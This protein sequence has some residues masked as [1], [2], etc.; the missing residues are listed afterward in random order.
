MNLRKNL[1]TTKNLNTTRN[2]RKYFISRMCGLTARAFSLTAREGPS[3]AS[4]R[5]TM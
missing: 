1:D 4:A 2:L 3:G 5:W